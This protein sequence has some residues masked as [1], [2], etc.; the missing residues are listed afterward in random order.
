MCFYT[1]FNDQGA[2]ALELVVMSGV[3]K[4]GAL[5]VLQRTVKPLLAS[6]FGLPGCDDIWTV[7]SR[8][9]CYKCCNIYYNSTQHS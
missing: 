4:S 3:D 6:T 1:Q 5:N 8:V 7:F 9:C 2:N